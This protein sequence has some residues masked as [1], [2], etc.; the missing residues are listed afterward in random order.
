MEATGKS[1]A[2]APS[3][4]IR[5]II[6]DLSLIDYHFTATILKFGSQGE[7]TVDYYRYSGAPGLD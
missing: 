7:K 4:W 1:S 3:A 5:T 2:N 6:L